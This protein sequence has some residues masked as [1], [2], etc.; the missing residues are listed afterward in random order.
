[1]PLQNLSSG[2][3]YVIR[4]FERKE[5][6]GVFNAAEDGKAAERNKVGK[7]YSGL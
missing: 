5:K 2:W 4:S 7:K 3:I 1:M 6:A